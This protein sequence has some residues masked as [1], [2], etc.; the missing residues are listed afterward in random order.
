MANSILKD[1]NPKRSLCVAKTGCGGFAAPWWPFV[2]H[3][4]H[5]PNFPLILNN[6]WLNGVIHKAIFSCDTFWLVEM[7]NHDIAWH[8]AYHTWVVDTGVVCREVSR[9]KIVNED[10]YKPTSCP[11]A[12]VYDYAC[13]SYED[14]HI[15]GHIMIGICWSYTSGH[16]IRLLVK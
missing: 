7:E 12:F 3:R 2:P 1:S 9:S 11:W 4:E 14:R 16:E 8:I 10:H 5:R 13:M 6:H 15:K